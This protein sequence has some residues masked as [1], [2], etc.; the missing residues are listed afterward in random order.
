MCIVCTCVCVPMC[1]S[2]QINMG[3]W[4]TEEITSS[5]VGVTDNYELY[6]VGHRNELW[7]LCSIESNLTLGSFGFKPKLI[8]KIVIY[9]SLQILKQ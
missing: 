7:S 8:L 9:F 3:S 4:M 5:V 6:E 2:A 1:E